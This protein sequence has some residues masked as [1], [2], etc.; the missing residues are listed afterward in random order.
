M[1]DLSRRAALKGA[2]AGSLLAMAMAVGLLRPADALADWN[3]GAFEA[4]TVGDALKNLQMAAP[5]ETRDIAIRA[6]DIE[7]FA[8]GREIFFYRAGSYDF[9][10]ASCHGED[11]KRIR[12]QQL[13]NFTKSDQAIRAFQG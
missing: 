13:P 2:G 5:V 10:C 3:K 12:T 1:T 8:V 7:T 11:G 4:K 6:P 9:S